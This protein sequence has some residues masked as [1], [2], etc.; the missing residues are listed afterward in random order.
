MKLDVT[1]EAQVKSL[2][3]DLPADLRNVDVLV[4]NAGLVV[5]M[6]TM[7]NVSTAAF[8]LM[9]D[10]NVKG[11]LWVTQAVLPGMKAR[12]SGHVINISS[13][14]GKEV[15][16]GG[17][18]YCATKHAVMALTN[19]LRLELLDSN[20]RVTSIL[21]GLVETEFSLVRFSGDQDRAKKVY[22]GLDPLHAQDVAETVV[23][24][25]NRP[26]HVQ[27]ADIT[28]FCTKQ[29]GATTVARSK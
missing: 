28:V 3:T 2:V 22:E 1:N 11:L 18:P 24:S 5:G 13:I 6:D 4:N 21:P 7:E 12:N 27:I 9:F 16:P 10:T 26:P 17:G 19:T 29:A 20:L 25:A 8:T 15:Y 23:F 14:S